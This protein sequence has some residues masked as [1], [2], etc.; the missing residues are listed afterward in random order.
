M[1]STRTCITG[2]TQLWY[3][4]SQEFALNVNFVYRCKGD[5]LV[6]DLSLTD[7]RIVQM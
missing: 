2:D 5:L 3:E 6:L 4:I 7:G 1:N